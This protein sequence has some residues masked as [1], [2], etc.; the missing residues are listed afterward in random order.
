MESALHIS[1]VSVVCHSHID[2]ISKLSILCT[3]K[4]R[5]SAQSSSILHN[6]THSFVNIDC[7]IEMIIATI[8]YS[9][10][11]SILNKTIKC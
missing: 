1:V 11:L 7:L 3:D 10:I 9:I 8:D 6:Q 4:H 5:Y 2:N